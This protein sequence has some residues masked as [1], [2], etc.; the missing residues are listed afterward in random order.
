MDAGQSI[1][2]ITCPPGYQDKP[3]WG[4]IDQGDTMVR[5]N[6]LAEA[7][8]SAAERGKSTGQDLQ[9]DDRSPQMPA[10]VLLPFA[11]SQPGR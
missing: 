10:A 11:G 6:L 4:T 3:T 8:L 9:N 7:A 5:A 2:T 1:P